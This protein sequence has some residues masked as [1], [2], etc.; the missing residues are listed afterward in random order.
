MKNIKPISR[1]L[2]VKDKARQQWGSFTDKDIEAIEGHRNPLGLEIEKLGES[3][4]ASFH[5]PSSFLEPPSVGSV[6]H[7]RGLTHYA[8]SEESARFHIR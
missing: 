7:S 4:S 2:K 5:P 8:V 1:W 6:H 3:E